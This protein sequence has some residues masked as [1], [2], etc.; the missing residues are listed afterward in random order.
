MYT[1]RVIPVYSVYISVVLFIII[2]FTVV[3]SLSVLNSLQILN[4]ILPSS[5]PSGHLTINSAQN[6]PGAIYSNGPVNQPR[7]LIF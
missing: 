7:K 5:D 4:G 1:K 2:Y 3:N 6:K